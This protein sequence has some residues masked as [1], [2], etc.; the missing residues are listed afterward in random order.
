METKKYKL[1][2]RVKITIDASAYGLHKGDKGT[3]K[4]LPLE[5]GTGDWFTRYGV[6][7]DKC[8]KG[9]NL[10]IKGLLS[11]AGLFCGPGVIAPAGY[12]LKLQWNKKNVNQKM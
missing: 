6:L 10:E 3:I 4:K 5:G 11:K 2:D 7:F 9:G 8:T 12:D 1:G